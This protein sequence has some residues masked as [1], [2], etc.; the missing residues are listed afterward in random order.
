MVSI[1]TWLIVL[2]GIYIALAIM[3]YLF[4]DKLIFRPEKLPLDFKFEYDFPF[5]EQFYDIDANI[6][7]NALYFFSP[8][9]KGLIFYFH[10]NRRSIKGYGKVSQDFTKNNYDV[11]MISYR[12]FGKSTGKITEKGILTD[13]QFIYKK[14]LS[15]WTE[16]K[17][18]IFGRSIGSGFATK[19]AALNKPKAL[20][21]DS[22]FYSFISVANKYTWFFP[23]QYLLRFPLRTYRW[24]KKVTCPIYI[25]H[26]TK[27]KLIPYRSAVRLRRL[28]RDNSMLL[29][30]KGG[31]H[32]NLRKFAEYHNK[33]RKILDGTLEV[34][35]RKLLYERSSIHSDEKIFNF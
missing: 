8:Q 34:G 3:I 4:Q 5:E 16:D 17:I 22:P 7:I 1:P 33:I 31:G 32:N 25:I 29:S 20:I 6:R 12:G 2:I 15:K 26:G 27:D 9:P 18:I 19:I 30:I 10:G 14:N 23:L 21:L 13:A 11:L 28:V 24:I 35:K